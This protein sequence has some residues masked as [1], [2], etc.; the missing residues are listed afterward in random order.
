MEPGSFLERGLIYAIDRKNRLES[1]KF[2]ILIGT[3][4]NSDKLNTL[5]DKYNEILYPHKAKENKKLEESMRLK[6]DAIKDKV[7]KAKV[8]SPKN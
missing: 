5:I 2:N 6:F 4:Q 3:L 1:I 8:R 7:I